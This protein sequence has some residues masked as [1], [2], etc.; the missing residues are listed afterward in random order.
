MDKLAD[1][2]KALP[3]MKAGNELI[4]ALTVLP[5][6]NRVKSE[7]ENVNFDELADGLETEI[8]AS[9]DG[10]GL[11]VDL[12]LNIDG[13]ILDELESAYSLLDTA[14]AEMDA[15]TGLSVNTI[16][17]L[18][19]AEEDYLDYL[20]KENGLIKLNTEA[21][22]ERANQRVNENL[23]VLR[24]EIGEL[25]TERNKALYNEL[26][27]I[28]D[29]DTAAAEKY[30]TDYEEYGSV[31]EEK[32]RQLDILETIFDSYN[33][34]VRDELDNTNALLSSIS[35]A[36]EILS[37]QSTGKSIS[38][39]EYNSAELQEYTSALEYHNGVLQ[40]NAEKVNEI[41]EA[42]A[43]EQIAI[44]DTN[45]AIKQSQYLANVAEIE[46]LRRELNYLSEDETEARNEVEA[47]IDALL[48]ENEVLRDS[49]TQFDLMSSSL[50]EAT[51]AY[52]HWLNAQDTANFIA[53]K[54]TLQRMSEQ[55]LSFG[56][57]YGFASAPS[58]TGLTDISS[59]LAKIREKTEANSGVN[60]GDITITIPI[61][62]VQDYNDFVRQMQH[63][64]QLEK[65]LQSMTV[66]R[67]VG[68]SSLKKYKFQF[69]NR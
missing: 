10:L 28:R 52:Q 61:E 64:P 20:Y 13:I 68:G 57:S 26:A 65:M 48:E 62:K 35:A 25:E 58:L 5:E 45:K 4:S 32:R 19:A 8:N 18:A 27:A 22:K 1:I 44:N 17:A 6:Y 7:L 15:G 21:W 49:C 55:G 3:P 67:L 14:Q 66:D 41:I 36:K 40:L 11:E 29:G 43:E 34:V 16:Q 69:G 63:D 38:I 51:S 23:D 33:D 2:I 42:K 24:T 30:H 37:A 60:V 54:E 39:A 31:L 12:D 47:N 56:S 53:L 46:K 59:K 9:L 50:R